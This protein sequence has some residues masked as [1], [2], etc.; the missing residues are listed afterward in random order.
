[1]LYS[2]YNFPSS[3]KNQ[4]EK[5]QDTVGMGIKR[6]Q[7]IRWN[8]R[9][10]AVHVFITKLDDIA[11]LL[12]DMASHISVS[13]DTRSDASYLLYKH[14]NFNLLNNAAVLRRPSA[15]ETSLPLNELQ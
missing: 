5:L 12:E 2:L 1:M 11:K 7:V 8:A 13:L 6:L 9:R 10:D 15:E 4:W 3:S 14:A